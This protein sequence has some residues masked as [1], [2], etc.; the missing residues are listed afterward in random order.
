M[1]S[2]SEVQQL[3]QMEAA[4]RNC[5]LMRNNSGAFKDNTGRLIRFGLDNTS[6]SRNKVIKSSDLIGIRTVIVTPEM[7][8]QTIG[9]FTAIEV[10]KEGWTRPTNEREFAQMHFIDFI[11]QRGGVAGFASS[12]ED[13]KKIILT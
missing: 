12:I 1:I 3:I 7:V 2:E 4:R 8:G 11:L 9:I 10:K 5:L 6:A 13:L